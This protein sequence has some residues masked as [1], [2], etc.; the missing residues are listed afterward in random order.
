VILYVG[1]L[2]DREIIFTGVY[3]LSVKEAQNYGMTNRFVILVTLALSALLCGCWSEAKEQSSSIG[4]PQPAADA[5]SAV[6]APNG[7]QTPTFVELEQP[8]FALVPTQSVQ[9]TQQPLADKKLIDPSVAPQSL[10]VLDPVQIRL[11]GVGSTLVS[12]ISVEAQFSTGEIANAIRIELRREDGT[13][14]TRSVID[15]ARLAPPGDHLNE[16]VDFEISDHSLDAWLIIGVDDAPN[17][18]L[19]V[20]SLPLV[21]SASGTSQPTPSA[22]Q[23]K[24]I[25]IQQPTP[26]AEISSGFVTVSGLT[27]LEP[28]QLL[29]AQ[30]LAQDGKVI[31]Q[32]LAEIDGSPGDQFKPFTIRLLQSVKQPTQARLVVFSELGQSGI[33]LHLASIPV[34]LSP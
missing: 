4:S 6:K 1:A 29:K 27:S 30:L 3:F 12:P 13:L 5:V 21:L 32:G 17:S 19:A 18:P 33:I 28:G 11:P 20:N 26:R 24:S 14:L 8:A 7:L 31:G 15:P 16:L 2:F 22:W 10:L 9:P 34:T 25:D 23:A